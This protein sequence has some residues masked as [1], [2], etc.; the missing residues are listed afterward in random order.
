MM[1]AAHELRYAPGSKLAPALFCA[2]KGQATAGP[3]VNLEVLSLV[4]GVGPPLQL[5]PAA[6]LA[7]GP[8]MVAVGSMEGRKR[9]ICASQ[10]QMDGGEESMSATKS[11]MEDG[12][13]ADIPECGGCAQPRTTDV[14]R[15]RKAVQADCGSLAVIPAGRSRSPRLPRGRGCRRSL[16]RGSGR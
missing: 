6:P 10:A 7:T 13:A 5:L 16:G 11:R 2:A 3:S 1:S 15:H 12:I 14:H 8:L 9:V 4:W